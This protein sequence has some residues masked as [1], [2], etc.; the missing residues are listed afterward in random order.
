[1]F[2]YIYLCK[3]LRL[4]V[5]NKKLLTYL[6]TYLLTVQLSHR[7]SYGRIRNPQKQF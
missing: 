3:T 2:F 5:F 4:S 6:L 1:M 7:R